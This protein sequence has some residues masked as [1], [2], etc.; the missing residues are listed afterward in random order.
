[1]SLDTD[2]LCA[3]AMGGPG[4]QLLQVATGRI[5]KHHTS[6]SMLKVG[7]PARSVRVLMPALLSLSVGDGLSARL[8]VS[9]SQAHLQI[10]Q[11]CGKH[12]RNIA[13]YTQRAGRG[14]S[15]RALG[16]RVAEDD[17]LL[18]AQQRVEVAIR[19]QLPQRLA[20]RGGHHADA[21]LRGGKAMRCCRGSCCPWPVVV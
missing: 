19:Q 14:M 7:A 1:M 2:M 11:Y 3:E 12:C 15:R 13:E 21:P 5:E 16:S 4:F 18:A 8:I 6:T 10:P 17:A 20:M 9:Q